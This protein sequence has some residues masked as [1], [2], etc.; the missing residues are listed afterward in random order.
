MPT[1][2]PNTRA[3]KSSKAPT[4]PPRTRQTSPALAA[5]STRFM[6]VEQKLAQQQQVQAL[7]A[8]EAK[9]GIHAC[10][11][12]AAWTRAHIPA[13]FLADEPALSTHCW[14]EYLYLSPIERTRRFT[15][16]YIL[17]YR[18]FAKSM[19]AFR[20]IAHL[21]PI[22]ECLELNAATNISC[23]WHARQQADELSIPYEKYLFPLF[24]H[25]IEVEGHSRLPLPNQLYHLAQL[26]H[27]VDTWEEWVRDG[28][29]VTRHWDDRL[30]AV[31][32]QGTKPQQ[33]C[34]D[35]L[36]H[37]IDRRLGRLEQ[38]MLTDGLLP[39]S[40]ARERLGDEMV[41]RALDRHG[42]ARGRLPHAPVS[43]YIPACLGLKVDSS[44]ACTGCEF[45]SACERTRRGVD[46]EMEA[47]YLSR[48]P[49]K[50]RERMLAR[51]RKRR[52]R[53]RNQNRDSART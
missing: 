48:D 53:E 6:S 19:I 39:E 40:I 47:I 22:H 9:G 52:Q 36:V 26:T 24:H 31:N 37:L 30:L 46:K 10:I 29:F 2:A 20:D 17:A 7:H 50:A 43:T 32:Y 15:A 1:N 16:E 45:V 28:T 38:F 41:D 51:D 11:G 33:H 34:H 42:S 27:V 18:H 49:R 4:K 14:P 3:S 23:L 25:A 44:A 8:A 35:V 5:K 13:E 12:R 21:C